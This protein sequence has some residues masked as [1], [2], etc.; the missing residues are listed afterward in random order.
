MYVSYK[1]WEREFFSTE[2]VH[3]IKVH[4]L[5]FFIN[6]FVFLIE[7]DVAIDKLLN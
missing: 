1:F 6:Q 4:T 5:F 7:Q 3:Q 2:L